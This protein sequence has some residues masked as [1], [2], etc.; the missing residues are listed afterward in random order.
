MFGSVGELIRP[1]PFHPTAA[2]YPSTF[3]KVDI[4]IFFFRNHSRSGINDY[5]TS[6]T[7]KMSDEEITYATVKF[8]KSSSGLQNEGR[9]DEAKGPTEAGHRGKCF[10]Y[11]N[12]PV[13]HVL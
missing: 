11:I 10:K 5:C 1:T 7:P 4:L 12:S 13:S 8:H 6:L 2:S 9:P 3:L